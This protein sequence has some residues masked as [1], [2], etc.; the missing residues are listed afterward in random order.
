MQLGERALVERVPTKIVNKK[1]INEDCLGCKL[2][3]VHP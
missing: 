1:T 3:D 2:S